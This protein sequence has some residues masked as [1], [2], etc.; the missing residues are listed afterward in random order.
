MRHQYS[1]SD[2]N[3]FDGNCVTCG[4]KFRDDVHRSSVQRFKVGDRVIDRD[5][6][7][8]SIRRVCHNGPD[9]LWYEVAMPGG[10]TVRY[11]SDL[12]LPEVIA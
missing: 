11:D 7:K 9:S 1:N 12:S 10:A 2:L 5:G 4:G 8:G 6:F 3:G